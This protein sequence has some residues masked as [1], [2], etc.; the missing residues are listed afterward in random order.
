MALSLFRTNIQRAESGIV[1]ILSGTIC[2]IYDTMPDGTAPVDVDGSVQVG[3]TKTVLYNDRDGSIVKSNP[4][5]AN[6]QGVIEAFLDTRTIHILCQTIDGSL[7]GIPWIAHINASILEDR[8][9]AIINVADYPTFQDAHDALPAEGG[10]IIVPLPKP[11]T[12]F[13]VYNHATVPAFT[14]MV[15]TKKV[16]IKGDGESGRK[17]AVRN[18][19]TG[20]EDVHSFDIQ[21]GGCAIENL[22]I[23]GAGL[24][25]IGNLI[26]FY[27]PGVNLQRLNVRN[28]DLLDASAWGFK[29]IADSGFFTDLV[30]FED[31]QFGTSQ[32]GGA[33]GGSG[34]SGSGDM[35]LGGGVGTGCNNYVF[36]NCRFFGP[37]Y[38][39]MEAGYKYGA[40]HLDQCSVVNFDSCEF[41]GNALSPFMSLNRFCFG[42]Y[43]DG[44]YIESPDAATPLTNN[45]HRFVFGPNAYVNNFRVNGMY[46]V[47]NSTS[48]L[49]KVHANAQLVFASLS[50]A[51]ISHIQGSDPTT[52]LTD[53]II[54]GS[55][56]IEFSMYDCGVADVGTGLKGPIRVETERTKIARYN[57]G[58]T[59]VR[60]V[61]DFPSVAAAIAATPNGGTLYFPEA[62]GPYI[63]PTVDGWEI[64]K[65]ITIL[66]D[67]NGLGGGE[68]TGFKY[69]NS[70]GGVNGSKNSFIFKL[71]AGAHGVTFKNI[72]ISN[73]LGKST[74][75]DGIG[76]GIYFGTDTII[77]NLRLE[78]VN[79]LYAGKHGIAIVGGDVG[80]SAYCVGLTLRN[81][82]VYGCVSDGIRL[83]LVTLPLFEFVTTWECDGKGIYCVA[84]FGL[85]LLTSHAEVCAKGLGYSDYNGQIVLENC[86]PFNMIGCHIENVVSGPGSAIGLVLNSCGSGNISGNVFVATT[87]QA[88]TIGINIVNGTRGVV[89][90][91]NHFDTFHHNVRIDNDAIN[92]G[93]T[94]LSN[95]SL[96][97]TG[98][99]PGLVTIPGVTRTMAFIQD[100]TA[101]V[102]NNKGVGLLLPN[103]P[104]HTL[105]DAAVIQDGLIVY[106]S[107]TDILYLRAAGAWVAL[108]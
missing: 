42:L 34:G 63:P 77:Q 24:A 43:I 68:G 84:C 90:G 35:L 81:V 104:D 74:E 9:G 25:G 88:G 51:M 54:F 39:E 79:V 96:T 19:A 31:V 29:T 105:V 46:A 76:C 7:F 4:L 59:S 101:G 50:D 28:C 97:N 94:I 55:D 10:V 65:S 100:A 72:V 78:N 5:I 52:W 8:G 3:A 75:T 62:G 11:I 16:H 44:V 89:I 15:I 86:R 58:I 57:R 87:E 93:N 45:A 71:V 60:N 99:A 64:N 13:D 12:G 6:T 80:V 82:N 32:Y 40:V 36:Y 98:T 30:Y 95:A 20:A 108:N 103:V 73:G 2:T 53:D 107:T 67:R 1:R 106:N 26:Q 47:L 83:N 37:G 48:R 66:G 17:P 38:G 70:I 69:F 14:G 22:E 49:M 91:G 33:Q 41:Q 27:K 102:A 61:L 21:V 23:I 18:F 85:N 56:N 92:T